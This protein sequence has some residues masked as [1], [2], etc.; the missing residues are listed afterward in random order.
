MTELEKILDTCSV[1]K[2]CT[3]GSYE[4]CLSVNGYYKIHKNN[5]IESMDQE[6]PQVLE[7]Q[8]RGNP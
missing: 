2:D 1:Y 6:K 4:M 8:E 3:D 5:Q 7:D